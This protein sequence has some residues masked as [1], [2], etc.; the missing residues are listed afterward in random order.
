M[1]AND[2]GHAIALAN[3]PSY[4][5]TG[6]IHS[7]DDREVARWCDE[8]EVG[9]AYIN[10]A[11]TGAIVQRQPFGGWKRSAIGPGA[12]A[13]GRHYVASLGTWHAG[14]P[15]RSAEQL[16]RARAAWEQLSVGDDPSGLRSET[17][18]FR[19]RA[20]R[21]VVVRVGVAIDPA[22]LRFALAVAQVVGV[23]VVVSAPAPVG[24]ADDAAPIEGYEA[25]VED[26]LGFIL[27]LSTLTVDKVRLL[28][29]AGEVGLAVIDAGLTLDPLDIVFDGEIELLRWTREQA[30]SETR[31]RHGNLRPPSA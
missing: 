5:L 1:R 16:E 10:R 12:K 31:H 21:R 20:L 13:G 6:G 14:D 3:Q 8:V 19:L 30:I 4:G 29:G 18:R 24:G 23:E 11:I 2:L 28:A 26:D 25:T 7:L 9:N 22:A 17:N 15:G 27:R